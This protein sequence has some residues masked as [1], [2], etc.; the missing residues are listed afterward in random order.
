M[1]KIKHV[2]TVSVNPIEKKECSLCGELIGS[3][4]WII[5]N[6]EHCPNCAAVFMAETLDGVAIFGHKYEFNNKE[7]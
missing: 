6:I 5:D 7:D 2:I 4:E 1:D 3:K